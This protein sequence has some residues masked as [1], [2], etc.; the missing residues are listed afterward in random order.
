MLRR[1]GSLQDLRF[2]LDRVHGLIPAC[3][4]DLWAWVD[5][6]RPRIGVWLAIWD[7]ERR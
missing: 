2:G 6:G 4:R 1:E 3:P 7:R 5:E